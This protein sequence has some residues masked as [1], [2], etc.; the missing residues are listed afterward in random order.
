MSF[1]MFIDYAD[2]NFLITL[3]YY[4]DSHN[5]IANV[6]HFYIQMTIVQQA[7]NKYTVNI[8]A[9]AIILTNIS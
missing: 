7:Q 9:H 1:R 5:I 2:V 4:Y 8:N 3:L 6:D